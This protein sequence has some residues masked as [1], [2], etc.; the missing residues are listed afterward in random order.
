MVSVTTI[1]LY[2]IGISFS[3]EP[4]GNSNYQYSLII[5]SR[6]WGWI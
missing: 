5:F 4:L 6:N 2:P 1:L 3:M